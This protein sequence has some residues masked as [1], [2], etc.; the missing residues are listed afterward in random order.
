[1]PWA[2]RTLIFRQLKG[3]QD[4]I[5]VAVVAPLMLSNG[6]ELKDDQYGLDYMY[7]LYLKMYDR[8]PLHYRRNYSWQE[9][10]RFGCHFPSALDNQGYL[11]WQPD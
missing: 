8:T 4:F 10:R 9:I 2:H 5:D 7:Q 11:R 3:L 6:W 1:M